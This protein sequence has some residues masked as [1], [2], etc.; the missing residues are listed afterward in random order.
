MNRQAQK[1]DITGLRGWDLSSLGFAGQEDF[2]KSPKP[3]FV[4]LRT[5]L[6]CSFKFNR[7]A[8]DGNPDY[9]LRHP[10]G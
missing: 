2:G 10:H 1:S 6:L 4:G 8:I 9:L 3:D 5:W 7:T